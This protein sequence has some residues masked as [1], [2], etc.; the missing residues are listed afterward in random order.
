M[1]VTSFADA[2]Q[3]I[4][5]TYAAAAAAFTTLDKLELYQSVVTATTHPEKV[6][7]FLELCYAQREHLPQNVLDAAADVGAFAT[8]MGFYGLGQDERGIKMVSALRGEE[9]QDLP[10]PVE[11]FVSTPPVDEA[12][13]PIV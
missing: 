9:V 1:Q 8:T 4:L 12:P 5:T 13:E 11:R 10:E 7:Q 3:L 2:D 6:S